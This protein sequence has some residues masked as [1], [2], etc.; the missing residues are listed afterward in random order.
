MVDRNAPLAELVRALPR[1]ELY[2]V[3]MRPTDRFEGPRTPNGAET[4]RQHLLFLSELEERGQLFA[5]GPLDLDPTA[6]RIEGICIIAANSIEEARDIAAREPYQ[7]AGMRANEV[8]RWQL[9]EG[10]SVAVAKQMV[11]GR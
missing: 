9:N 3:F 5:S 10:L 8:R 6:D 11:R 2:A 1:I 7:V 4:L